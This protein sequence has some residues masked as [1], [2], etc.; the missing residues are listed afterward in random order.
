MR[1]SLCLLGSLLVLTSGC[2]DSGNN[3]N[4]TRLLFF[5]NSDGA[6]LTDSELRLTGVSPQTGWFTERPIRAAGQ[7]RTE[8]VLLA[9]GDGE[10]SFTDDPPNA[11]FTCT[12][13]GEV[14]D[15]VVELQNPSLAVPYPAEGCDSGACTLIYAITFVGSAAVEAGRRLDCDGPGHLFIDTLDCFAIQNVLPIFE[16]CDG[17]SFD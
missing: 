2:G 3:P 10:N 6:I 8:D 16:A 9:W 11:N 15:H 7:V 12:V 13:D 5:Q 17:S 4:E 1:K 14:I